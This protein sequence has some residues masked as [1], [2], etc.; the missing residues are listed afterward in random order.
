L[1]ESAGVAARALFRVGGKTD[2]LHGSPLEA[3]CTVVSLHDGRFEEPEPRHGGFAEMD[4]GRTAIVR[5]QSGL[6]I[7]LTSRRMPPFSLRQ[8]TSCGLDPSAF[9]LIV[10]KGVNAPVAAYAPVCQQFIRVNTPGVTTA[11]MRSLNYHHRRRPMF[12]FEEWGDGMME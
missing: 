3:D 10:A 6:T 12:P 8:L 5:T 2:A 7:M 1:A 9:D 11:D 4:Q